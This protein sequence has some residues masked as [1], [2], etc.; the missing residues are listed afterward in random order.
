M[1]LDINQLLKLYELQINEG[2][3]YLKV[4][5]NRIGFYSGLIS[6]IIGGIIYSITSFISSPIFPGLLIA[7]LLL[8]AA[9]SQLAIIGT[10]RQY[11]QL[12]ENIT[13]RAKIEIKLGLTESITDNKIAKVINWESEPIVATRHLK[14]RKEYR[15]SEKFI[16]DK[17]GKGYNSWPRAILR[18]IQI[19]CGIAIIIVLTSVYWQPHFI[20]S[21]LSPWI[22][23]FNL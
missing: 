10:D 9:I 14:S 22:A 15:T 16:N 3:V 8:L 19:F 12:L 2:H 20:R 13:V 21:P 11:R 1:K 6:A 4:Y 7:E 5:E 18:G 17:L 23:R